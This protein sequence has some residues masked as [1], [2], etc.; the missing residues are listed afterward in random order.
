MPY[1]SS[2]VSRGCETRIANPEERLLLLLLSTESILSEAAA[3]SGRLYRFPVVWQSMG[4]AGMAMETA[5]SPASLT[6]S[7]LYRYLVE[8][9]KKFLRLSFHFQAKAE[10][11]IKDFLYSSAVWMIFW[12]FK[13]VSNQHKLSNLQ[14]AINYI[15]RSIAV[16]VL[17]KCKDHN[18]HIHVP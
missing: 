12:S 17:G 13:S 4:T 16:S 1:A 7:L 3:V 14:P 6:H 9:L 11:K 8:S 2:L 18:T 10:V 15:Q 5:S